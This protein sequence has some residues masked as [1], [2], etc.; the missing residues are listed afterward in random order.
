MKKMLL[1]GRRRLSCESA[2]A[3]WEEEMYGTVDEDIGFRA[4]GLINSSSMLG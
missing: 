3:A 2:I 4:T 1:K